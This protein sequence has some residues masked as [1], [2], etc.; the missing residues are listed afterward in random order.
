MRNA[1]YGALTGILAAATLAIMAGCSIPATIDAD[2]LGKSIGDAVGSKIASSSAETN[3][4]LDSLGAL[5]ATKSLTPE[6]MTTA[7]STALKANQPSPAPAQTTAPGTGSTDTT[8]PTTQRIEMSNMTVRKVDGATLQISVEFE[9]ATPKTWDSV[10]LGIDLG[11][12]KV[13][14]KSVSAYTGL[15][16]YFPNEILGA[17]TFKIKSAMSVMKAGQEPVIKAGKV[18]EITLEGTGSVAVSSPSPTP[19]SGGS[20]TQSTKLTEGQALTRLAAAADRMSWTL[21]SLLSGVWKKLNGQPLTDAE[22]AAI[23]DGVLSGAKK[24][25]IVGSHTLEGAPLTSDLV[26]YNAASASATINVPAGSGNGRICVLTG[27]VIDAVLD[28]SVIQGN[29][30]NYFFLSPVGQWRLQW[31]ARVALQNQ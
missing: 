15:P 23:Q 1:N 16:E 18:A 29:S 30:V 22:K 24:L 20:T 3:A 9:N 7:L 27:S 11:N 21:S 17:G 8:T 14:T 5:I 31:N 4:K 25:G 10:L 28:E 12:G 13:A 26:T 19:A 6:Q 2:K